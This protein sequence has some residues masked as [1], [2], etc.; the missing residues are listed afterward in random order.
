MGIEFTY[1]N[2]DGDEIVIEF[3]SKKEVCY[4]CDGEGTHLNPSIGEHAYSYEEFNESFDDEG[5]EQYFKPGGIY[6]VTCHTCHG[7]NVVDVHDEEAIKLDPELA[8]HYE[9]YLE[10]QSDDAAYDAECMAEE[11]FGC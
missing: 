9:V 3:P 2:D 5:K 7:K 8:A 10:H 4:R 6:D 1:E 11:R